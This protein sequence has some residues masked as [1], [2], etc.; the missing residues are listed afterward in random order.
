MFLLNKRFHKN[1]AI[2]FGLSLLC[3][4]Y[5]S[6]SF[7]LESSPVFLTM[8]ISSII[9][10][11]RIDKIKDFSLYLF[12]I[13][14]IANFVDYL[15]VPL[16]TLGMLCCLYILKLLENGKDWKYCARFL[17]FHSIVWITGYACT[18][19]SKWILYDL[20]IESFESMLNIGFT[21]SFYRMT[22]DNDYALGETN[23]FNTIYKIL[24]NSSFFILIS[25]W[26]MMAI[27]KFKINIEKFNKNAIPFLLLSLL[28]VG[29]YIVLAN[30]TMLHAYFT[31]RHSLVFMLGILLAINELLFQKNMIKKH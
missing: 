26:I 2:I 13:A 12:I 25:L 11:K 19:V 27:N 5:F 17:I 10:L 4:G 1:V 18:W 16:I 29:W 31:Y 30:H 15:T 22:R 14:C 8:M 28:P 3:S 21:Q 9:L 6:V 7:S 23:Y 24:S 20:T